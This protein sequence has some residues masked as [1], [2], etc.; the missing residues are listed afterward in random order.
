M[1]LYET[2]M[3]AICRSIGLAAFMVSAT[4]LLIAIVAYFVLLK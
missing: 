2:H 1:D 4:L 3:Q